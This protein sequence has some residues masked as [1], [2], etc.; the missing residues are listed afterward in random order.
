ME[1]CR[2]EEL[3]KDISCPNLRN[4]LVKVCK[5]KKTMPL[6]KKS[7]PINIPS[8]KSDVKHSQN[9]NIGDN[10]SEDDSDSDEEFVP[11]HIIIA[12]RK[13]PDKMAYPMCVGKGRTLKGRDLIEMRDFVHKLTGFI[14]S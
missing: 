10:L 8:R 7:A 11:P 12:N 6:F 4:E 2:Y 1:E 9:I 14:E 13:F 5:D 3:R